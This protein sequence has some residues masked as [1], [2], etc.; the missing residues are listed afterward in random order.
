MGV[1]CGNARYMKRFREDRPSDFCFARGTFNA[2]PYV[3]G[4]MY[5]F[6]RRHRRAEAC[7]APT[8]GSTRRGTHGWGA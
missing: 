3:M 7:G 4:A 2:H 1:L 6:L 8:S 5:E